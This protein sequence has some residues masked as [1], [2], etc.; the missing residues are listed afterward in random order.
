[1]LRAP[2]RGVLLHVWSAGVSISLLRPVPP[3]GPIGSALGASM[4]LWDDV[5]LDPILG[6]PHR[7]LT[8]THC[9]VERVREEWEWGAG[10][11]LVLRCS[12]PAEDFDRFQDV[13]GQVADSV[14]PGEPTAVPGV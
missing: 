12:C 4:V 11:G 13:F 1:M 10:P 3:R 9:G 8:V 2:E 6:V 14:R 7:V 5:E